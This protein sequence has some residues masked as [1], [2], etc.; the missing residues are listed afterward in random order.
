VSQLAALY[1]RFAKQNCLLLDNFD[2]IWFKMPASPSAAA[3][4][5][6]CALTLSRAG[7]R[8]RHG[9]LNAAFIVFTADGAD[10]IVA[11]DKP[12]DDQTQDHTLAGDCI[13]L[14]TR[15]E[16]KTIAHLLEPLVRQLLVKTTPEPPVD[17]FE[18]FL[19]RAEIYLRV[20][21]G[22]E[23]L[24]PYPDFRFDMMPEPIDW[25]LMKKRVSHLGGRIYQLSDVTKF[26]QLTRR[27]YEVTVDGETVI[28]KRAETYYSLR[29][30]MTG[31]QGA[32]LLNIR[33]PRLVGVIG[34]DTIWGGLLMTLVPA[35]SDLSDLNCSGDSAPRLQATTA[36]R[37]Q[38]FDE[39]FAAF[40]GFHR[41]GFAYGDVKPANILIDDDRQA[42]LIDFEGGVTQGWVDEDLL[43]T[44]EGDLQGLGRLREFLGLEE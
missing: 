38:W 22:A 34:A 7:H 40:D 29:R 41:Y 26:R 10:Y 15:G 24:E 2:E 36:E 42:W 1:A 43:D 6:D 3:P 14:F 21:S 8:A 9:V 37:Q 25:D 16:Y 18:S 39:I 5:D 30:E 12:D 35:S 28:Y 20:V 33:A 13:G 44:V 27:V 4:R 23:T 31:L 32:E 11:F 19:S 17:T